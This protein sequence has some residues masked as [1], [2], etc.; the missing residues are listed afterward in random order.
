[1]YTYT[2]WEFW[3]LLSFT[4]WAVYF[5]P[6]RWYNFVK[7]IK[8][9]DRSKIKDWDN[10]DFIFMLASPFLLIFWIW[11][12]LMQLGYDEVAGDFAKAIAN[13]FERNS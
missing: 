2:D 9:N 6:K 10:S 4:I 8:T 3:L 13:F 7:M 12:L 5:I 1:M 11:F